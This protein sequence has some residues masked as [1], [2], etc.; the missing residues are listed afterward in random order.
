MRQRW[1]FPSRNVLVAAALPLLAACADQPTGERGPLPAE[2]GRPASAGMQGRTGLSHLPAPA[3]MAAL[4]ASLQRHYPAEFRATGRRGA[5]LVEVSV[6]EQ[7]AVR[8]VE[9]VP[10]ATGADPHAVTRAVLQER[11]R[12]TGGVTERVLALD[13]DPAFGPAAVAA[14]R[15]TRFT[16]AVRGADGRPVAYRFRMT[17]VFDPPRGAS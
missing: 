4:D 14:L 15:E 6:D 2:T 8:G 7:G 1:N 11:D 3:D 9:V 17:L 13:H 5:V 10:R 16:P 12:E